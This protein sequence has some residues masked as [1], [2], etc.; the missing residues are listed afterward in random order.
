MTEAGRHK[1]FSTPFA[2]EDADLSRCVHCGLCLQSCP[3]YIELGLETESPRG[4]LYLMKGISKGRIE[5][6]AGV[7]AHLDLCLQ[8]R[9]CEAV[10]PSGVP[11]GRIMEDARADTVAAHHAPFSWRVRIFFLRAFILRP[12]LLRTLVSILRIVDRSGLRALGSRVPLTGLRNLFCLLPQVR[13]RPFKKT[14]VLATPEATPQRRVAFFSGCVMPLLH[15]RVHEATI[16]VLARNGCWV[17]APPEQ[18]CCGALFSHSGDRATAVKLAKRNL[19]AFVA[20]E[21]DVVIVNSAGCGAALKEYPHLFHDDPNYS[22]KAQ[23]FSAL[24]RDISEFLVE[25]DPLSSAEAITATVTYQDSCHLGHAQ[26]VREQPRQLLRSIPGVQFVEMDNA[27]RCCGSAGIYNLTQPEMSGQLLEGKIR[28][29]KETDADIIATSNPGC[30]LQLETG[31]RRERLRG[32]VMHV[33]E[34]LDEAYS[35]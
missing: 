8:C 7:L 14:G 13:G 29:V 10:C 23:R 25:L 27:D 9:N 16:R 17:V 1:G 28:A 2:P 11:F 21:F 32:R 3:T 15:G 33:V 4:R 31:L 19:D 35:R 6:T 22:E 5:P 30:I 12:W 20:D 24:V 18:T 34:L 26:G